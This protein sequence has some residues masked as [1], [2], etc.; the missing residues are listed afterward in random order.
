MNLGGYQS[1]NG[2]YSKPQ[3]NQ[4]ELLVVHKEFFN[5]IHILEE[6]EKLPVSTSSIISED[7]YD[8]IENENIVNSSWGLK[9]AEKT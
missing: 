7:I 5:Q 1:K 6:I 3:Y 8:E 4:E 2:E 9:S